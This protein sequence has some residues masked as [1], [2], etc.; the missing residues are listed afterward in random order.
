MN[1]VLLLIS[2]IF[3][4][5]MLILAVKYFGEGGAYAWIAVASILA[6]IAVCKS[7]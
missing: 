2:I 4:F 7:V 5:S 3:I 1:I 6:E